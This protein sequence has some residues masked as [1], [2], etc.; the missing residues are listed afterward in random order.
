M[1]GVYLV[2]IDDRLNFLLN[3]MPDRNFINIIRNSGGQLGSPSKKINAQYRA[4]LINKKIQNNVAPK[5]LKAI[6]SEVST[7]GNNNSENNDTISLLCRAYLKKD[8]ETFNLYKSKY[9][10]SNSKEIS[11]DTG[12]KSV[13]KNDNKHLEKVI[14]KQKDKIV[15]LNNKYQS[16]AVV[17]KKMQVKVDQLEGINSENSQLITSQNE[18]IKKM[19]DNISDLKSKLTLKNSS[20]NVNGIYIKEITSLKSKLKVTLRNEKTLKE[21]NTNLREE[22]VKLQEQIDRLAAKNYILIGMPIGFK[23]GSIKIP[24]TARLQIAVNSTYMN[25]KDSQIIS[26]VS[27]DNL[28]SKLDDPLTAYEK[29]IIFNGEVTRKDII[30]L[31]NKVGENHLAY[32]DNINELEQMLNG[33]EEK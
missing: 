24:R 12:Q 3:I 1:R 14:E 18:Q 27:I 5:V 33:N 17:V 28:I 29:I 11:N 2:K 32:I 8:S 30:E 31:I 20:R 10:K 16:E 19:A 26:Y 4:F 15:S 25:V 13:K 9:I 22:T 7:I 21:E 6:I 23:Y